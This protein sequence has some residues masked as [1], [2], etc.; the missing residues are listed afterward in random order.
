MKT[1]LIALLLCGCVDTKEDTYKLTD[2]VG[3]VEGYIENVD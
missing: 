1:I 2:S 3:R